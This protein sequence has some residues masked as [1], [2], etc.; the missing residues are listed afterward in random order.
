MLAAAIAFVFGTFVGSFLNVC[1][2]RLP[3]NESIVLPPSRCYSCG[4][5][6]AWYDNL[7]VLSW[8]VLRGRCRW[9]GAGFSVKYLL[10]EVGVGLLA[11][12]VAWLALGDGSPRLGE[13]PAH[14]IATLGAHEA[15]ATGI[16]A[17]A[18]M[19]LLFYLV[20]ATA[21]DLEHLIIPDELTKSFQVAA[22]LLAAACSTN[23]AVG[24]A[25]VDWLAVPTPNPL[26]GDPPVSYEPAAFLAWFLGIA[27]GSLILLAAS[28]PL[29]RAVYSRF[30]PEPQRWRPVDHRGFRLGV[31][32]FVA[33]MV[34]A[35]VAVAVLMSLPAAPWRWSLSVSLAQAVLGGLAGWGSLYLV[36]L[37]GTVAFRRNA[38]G[39]GDVKFLAPI[40][41]FLGP[42]G[43]LYAFAAAAAFGL[44]VGLPLR[45]LHARREIP[46][47][48]WLAAGSLVVLA[49][50]PELHRLTMRF[51]GVP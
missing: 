10:F 2:H 40:G 29:A 43:V 14:W 11:A 51:I 9:C 17:A 22:P 42:V 37:L 30:L 7:P 18:V 39:F 41:C 13:W 28:L 24:W 36:G 23:L 8:L 27:V 48:P 15:L 12:G 26:R 21:T 5:R 32:W 31:L 45:L 4:T 3:R 25:C 16:A 38:M 35:I 49:V 6:V 44:L 34:P 50:G 46:F 20:V 19:S 47:G 33:A 1:A